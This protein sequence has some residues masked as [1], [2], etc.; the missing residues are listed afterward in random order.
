MYLEILEKTNLGGRKRKE[1]C[2]FH[3]CLRW[4]LLKKKRKKEKKQTCLVGGTTF[5]SKFQLDSTLVV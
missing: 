3:A 2:S 4:F 1:N 5:S